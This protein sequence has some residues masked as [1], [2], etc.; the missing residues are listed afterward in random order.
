MAMNRH[1]ARTS[2]D[3]WLERLF[4]PAV[5]GVMFGSIAF[6]LV[7]LVRLIFPAWNGTF[8]V[9]GC[10]LA[11]LEANYSYQMIRS[12]SLRGEDLLRFRAIEIAM[13]FPLLK[14]GSYVGDSWISLWT[15]I[16]TWPHNLYRFFDAE[17]VAAFILAIAS[18]HVSTQTTRDFERLNEPAHYHRHY[19]SP[20]ERLTGRFFGGGVVL[21][22]AAGLTR[23]GIAQLLD[24]RR[25][26]VPGLVLNVLI[27]FLLGL[28]MLGQ[29][30]FAT[31][32]KRWQTQEIKVVDD[33]AGRWVR[34]SLSFIGIVALLAFLLPTG[35]TLGLLEVISWILGTIMAIMS[36]IVALVLWLAT[37][38]LAWLFSLMGTQPTIPYLR[39]PPP[40]L[41]QQESVASAAP[42]WFQ[43]LRSLVFWTMALGMLFYVVRSYLRDHPDLLQTLAGLGPVRVLRGLWIA[44]R[45]WLR[46]WSEA[47]S[48]RVPSRW[49]IRLTRGAAKSRE[50]FRFLRLRALSPR[51]QVLYY[52]LSILERA[53]Q[54]GFPRQRTQTPHEYSATLEPNLP[55]AQQEMGL[56]TEAFVEARYSQ[57]AIE[58]DQARNVRANWRQVK[59]TLRAIKPRTGT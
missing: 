9:V 26:A 33:L 51:D 17:T 44:L 54:H 53:R 31:L 59:A 32:R 49:R 19:V 45:G 2:R 14:I 48:D 15:D 40:Q 7:E 36:L 12:K 3:I 18:W 6:S 43:I 16:Q 22:I 37:L 56:L 39:Q 52:Y 34:Y 47:L 4:R 5:I 13:F 58:S 28:V 11:A 57:H 46:G 35:Y 29:V 55:G 10:V 20:M 8:L 21:L 30:R 23:I 38:P 50:S 1:Q 27:Y 24:L 41:T 25:P 42:D